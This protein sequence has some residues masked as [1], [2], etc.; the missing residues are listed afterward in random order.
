MGQKQT[1]AK[2]QLQLMLDA[3]AAPSPQLLNLLAH[4]KAGVIALLRPEN[5]GW[6]AYDWLAYFDE[7][8]G[9]V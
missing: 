4:H 9:I 5:D 2:C 1:S 3:D 8:A 7:R 6:S